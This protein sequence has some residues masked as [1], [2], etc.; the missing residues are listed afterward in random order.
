MEV[1]K[2][3]F[4]CYQ[5]KKTTSLIGKSIG[6]GLFNYEQK[7]G[8]PFGP[9]TA[10]EVLQ[11]IVHH[12]TECGFALRETAWQAIENE[13]DLDIL[14]MLLVYACT[15][16]REIKFWGTRKF[17]FESPELWPNMKKALLSGW[18]KS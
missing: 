6:L 14:K 16:E 13:K 5:P 2:Q 18:N 10:E 17:I 9:S 8:K 7:T 4:T 12:V 1:E 3:C 11:R 15:Q